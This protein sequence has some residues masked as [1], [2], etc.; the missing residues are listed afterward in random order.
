MVINVVVEEV[1]HASDLSSAG[2][3]RVEEEEKEARGV[4]IW[5]GVCFCS[6]E[7][8]SYAFASCSK[9][10]TI[11]CIL[12]ASERACTFRASRISSPTI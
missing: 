11:S 2:D 9:L 6:R 1:D 12:V 3:G 8:A 10:P 4:R 5:R 7:R